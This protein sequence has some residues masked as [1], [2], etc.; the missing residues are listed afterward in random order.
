MVMRLAEAP[1]YRVNALHAS[2]G[3][4]STSI[5]SAG[6]SVMC[7]RVAARQPSIARANTAGSRSGAIRNVRS[8]AA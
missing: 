3:A 8:N 5:R 1:W 4:Y 2:T 6:G 7:A